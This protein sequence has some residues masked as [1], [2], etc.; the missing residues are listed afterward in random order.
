MGA[1]ITPVLALT[2]TVLVLIAVFAFAAVVL[3]S[4]ARRKE[5][6]AL[7]RSD[8]LKHLALNPGPGS[9]SVLQHLREEEQS[10]LDRRRK[11]LM[12]TGMVCAIGGIG[13]LVALLLLTPAEPQDRPGFLVVGLLP[14]FVGLGLAFGARWLLR[15][16]QT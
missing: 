6:E 8:L 2:F 10:K 15:R 4:D 12:L 3:W 7:H 11:S 14:V 13:L 5:R 9:E 1:S 16:P